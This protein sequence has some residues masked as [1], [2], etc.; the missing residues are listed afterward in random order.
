MSELAGP[1]QVALITCR[2]DRNGLIPVAWHTPLSK[3]PN[4]YAVVIGKTRSSH[5]II[6]ESGTFC[7]NFVSSDALDLVK[8]AGSSTSEDTDKFEEFDIGKEEC[9]KIE[10][11]RLKDSLGFLECKVIRQ[12][13]AG[14][15]DIFIG[16]IVNQRSKAQ[17]KRLYHITGDRFA[18]SEE[19]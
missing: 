2:S 1:R 7:V 12:V 16:E 8:K 18:V 3:Q 19:I 15:H 17:G 10:S 6:S 14:D 13:D 5:G 11:P 9:E 4:L